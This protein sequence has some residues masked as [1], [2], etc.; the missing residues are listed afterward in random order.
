MH[1]GR[2]PTLAAVLDH[3]ARRAPITGAEKRDVIAFLE[4]LTD[5]ELLDPGRWAGAASAR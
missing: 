1:D 3:Y 2:F 4:S 5:P